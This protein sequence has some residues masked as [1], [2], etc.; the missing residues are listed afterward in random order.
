VWRIN[1]INLLAVD[2][3]S[4]SIASLWERPVVAAQSRD[5]T[6][7]AEIESMAALPNTQVE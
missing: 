3:R 4:G 1:L 6:L 5:E 7:R 2:G